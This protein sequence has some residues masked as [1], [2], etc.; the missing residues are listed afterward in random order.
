MPWQRD[1]H[2]MHA[3]FKDNLA[4]LAETLMPHNMSTKALRA[5][6]T[7]GITYAADG[8]KDTAQDK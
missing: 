6:I 3:E 8:L 4:V 2:R 7:Y 1:P 5:S